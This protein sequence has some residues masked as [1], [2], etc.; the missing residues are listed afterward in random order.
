MTTKELVPVSES[1]TS[2]NSV[3]NATAP[4]T[5]IHLITSIKR[6]PLLFLLTFIAVL[7]IGGLAVHRRLS[8]SYV[9]ESVVYVSPIFPKE[10]ADDHDHDRQY[11]VFIEQQITAVPQYDTL[12]EA[13]A[14]NPGT[15]T[16]PHESEQDAVTRLQAALKVA[17]KGRSYLV[18]ITLQAASPNHLAD[19]VNSITEIYLRKARQE[20]FFGT[21][22]RLKTLG[23]EKER[24]QQLLDGKLKEQA[25]LLQEMGMAHF[26]STAVVAPLD[27]ELGKLREELAD[28]HAKR[29]EADARLTALSSSAS[30]TGLTTLDEAAESEANQDPS[31]SSLKTQLA[32]HRALLLAQMDGLTVQNPLRKQAEAQLKQTDEQLDQ[33]SKDYRRRKSLEIR[34]RYEGER[35]RAS[36]LESQLQSDLMRTMG[37]VVAAG[38]KMQ[39][40]EIL[41]SEIDRIKIAYGV[42][43]AR[44]QSLTLEGSSP[45]SVHLDS[46]AMVPTSPASRKTAL[47]FGGLLL[48]SIFAGAC[49][50]VIANLLDSKIYNSDEVRNIIGFPPI[51]LLLAES[52][53]SQEMEDEYFT[54]LT[55]GIDQALRRTGARTFAFTSV[56]NSNVSSIVKRLSSELSLNGLRTL[57]ILASSSA[58]PSVS[59][60]RS[61]SAG[62]ENGLSRENVGAEATPLVLKSQKANGNSLSGVLVMNPAS[63][64]QF[65]RENRSF[66]DSI[67]IASDPILTSAHTEN[68]TRVADGTVLVID[69]G[70]TTKDQMARAAKLLER[71]KIPGIAVVLQNINHKNADYFVAR[72]AID[73]AAS[74]SEVH[75]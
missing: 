57:V 24:T 67:L 38:P 16:L 31:I 40:A 26:D 3:E 6:H 7:V 43:D 65:L 14:A 66:F 74:G 32:S 37:S 45:G 70:Q 35:S 48:V 61:S 60:I 1:P 64:P 55:G 49:A 17:Q 44:I 53:F 39:R 54:R 11:D 18:G 21:D 25:V 13:L 12:R 41:A 8:P 56:G 5:Q 42:L 27:T 10:L 33:V 19:L 30:G 20:E 15:W 71:L 34:Q 36:K 28:A 2:S 47:Y 73:Y 58:T 69:S 29:V 50:S 23:A 46:P 72:S 68:L 9:A 63:V 4:R 51:G 52:E 22:A 59:E 62:E 75:S